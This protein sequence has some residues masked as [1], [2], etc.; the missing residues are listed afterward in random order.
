[1]RIHR[2]I[3]GVLVVVLA[4]PTLIAAQQT[5]RSAADPWAAVK[6]I[7]T[8]SDLVVKLK[9]GKKMKSSY[10]SAT[11]DAISLSQGNTV[12]A[13]PRDSIATIHLIATSKS[14]DTGGAIGA[15]AGVGL[16][17]AIAVDG[18]GGDT[19]VLTIVVSA[20]I[21]GALGYLFG[22]MFSPKYKRVLIYDAEI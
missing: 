2:L 21:F 9:S 1:M 12:T 11:D 3:I 17:V 6:T 13:T 14:R 15:T 4:H 18:S 5:A 7:Q 20:L 16:G 19:P 10:V 22:W 8:G